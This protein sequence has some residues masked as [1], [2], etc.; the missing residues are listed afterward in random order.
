MTLAIAVLRAD[1]RWFLE[2]GGGRRERGERG[3]GGGLAWVR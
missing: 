2:G 1:D 3:R